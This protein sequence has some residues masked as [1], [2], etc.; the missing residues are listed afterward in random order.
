MKIVFYLS[1]VLIF[2]GCGSS[3]F[4]QT[5]AVQLSKPKLTIDKV[6]FEEYTMIY[7]RDTEH[8]ADI[9]YKV[10]EGD[11]VMY[12]KPI[13]VN[14]SQ[15]INFVAIGD[16]FIESDPIEIKVVKLPENPII[17]I[18][19]NRV[20]NEKYK[21][22]GLDILLDRKKG[23][24]DFNQGWLGYSGDTVDY[25]IEFEEKKLDRVKVSVL[26][27][28]KNWIFIPHKVEVYNKGKLIGSI[29]SDNAMKPKSNG[30]E[31]IDVTFPSIIS[32]ELDIKVVAHESLPNWH[33]GV[34]HKPWIF[35]DE[36]LVY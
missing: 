29:E 16:G 15:A 17:N 36:I 9:M 27:N 3:H 7:A 14:K 21:S 12:S 2:L 10:D 6:F 8:G 13:S 24:S 23:K 28:Q 32:N 31:F 30:I 18:Y 33:P 1:V 11:K 35:I 34:G 25:R 22:G 26:R 19:S 5:E 20:L 4:L